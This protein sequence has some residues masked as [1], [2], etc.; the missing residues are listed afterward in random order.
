M[1]PRSLLVWIGPTE[2]VRDDVM[3]LLCSAHADRLTVPL[4]WTLVDE[5]MGPTESPVIEPIAVTE[6]P[7]IEPP[8]IEPPVIE[9]P[10]TEVPV[11]E[12]PVI[13][14][15]SD[16][17]LQG[18]LF[19]DGNTIS[20]D[21]MADDAIAGDVIEEYEIDLLDE[22]DQIEGFDDVEDDR[23]P[24]WP[25]VGA[26]DPDDTGPLPDVSGP[27]LSRAFRGQGPPSPEATEHR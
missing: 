2:P 18:L 21:P 27:L 17:P 10:V 4:G 5:R 7:V 24:S 23:S 3:A 20:G 8:V 12:P 22:F 16:R 14:P 15:E 19:D 6:V 25:P 13:E 1:S 9:P 26:F 11:I